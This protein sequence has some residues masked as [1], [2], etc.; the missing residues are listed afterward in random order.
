MSTETTPKKATHAVLTQHLPS[1]I[2]SLIVAAIIF[3]AS[4]F[5][6]S[7]VESALWEERAKHYETEL[8]ELNA[9]I[10]HIEGTRYSKE[11]AA[12]D[13]EIIIQKIEMVR[14]E[15]KAGLRELKE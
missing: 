4:S 8:Q 2:V 10:T 6:R 12:K 14:L 15:L 11:D 9:R 7:E 3:A 5:G 1:I 13:N